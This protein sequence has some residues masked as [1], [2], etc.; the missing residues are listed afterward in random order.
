M[1][2]LP[3]FDTAFRAVHRE[4][5]YAD[6]VK[7]G[8]PVIQELKRS[9]EPDGAPGGRVYTA[10]ASTARPAADFTAR[11]IPHFEG[12]DLPLEEARILWQR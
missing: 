6:G 12:V 1:E 3:E 10:A 5:L 9:E 11:A 4:L 8:A 7:G 2:T